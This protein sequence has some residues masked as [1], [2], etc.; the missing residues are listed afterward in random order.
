MKYYVFLD[1]E[2]KPVIRDAA[3]IDNHDPTFWNRA[4]SSGIVWKVDISD[5]GSILALLQALQRKRLSTEIV[6]NICSGISVDLESFMKK[7]ANK[8]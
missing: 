6:R 2:D 8:K 1:S 3:Y 4:P 7:L 5:D